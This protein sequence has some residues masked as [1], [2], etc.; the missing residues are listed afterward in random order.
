MFRSLALPNS[1]NKVYTLKRK[2]LCGLTFLILAACFTSG[3][4]SGPS[5]RFSTELLEALDEGFI[6]VNQLI[7]V[8]LQEKDGSGITG[9]SR[10]FRICI[11]K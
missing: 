9:T 7:K 10:F 6:D 3:C 8:T 4:E 11:I 2:F 5:S 1:N